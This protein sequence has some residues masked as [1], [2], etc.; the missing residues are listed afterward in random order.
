MLEKN[1]TP[2]KNKQ[3]SKQKLMVQYSK[4]KN[5]QDALPLLLGHFPLQQTKKK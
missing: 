3:T 5:I 2:R 4:S 1:N